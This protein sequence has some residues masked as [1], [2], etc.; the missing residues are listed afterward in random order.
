M[1]RLLLL[2]AGLLLS[3]CIQRPAIPN[4]AGSQLVGR[5]VSLKLPLHRAG[6]VM[7]LA[8]EKGKV[9]L[10]DLWATWCEPCV[11][12]LQVYQ[13]LQKEYGDRGLQIYAINVDDD[14]AAVDRFVDQ[15][16]LTLPVPL[17]PNSAVTAELLNVNQLPTSVLIDRKGKVRVVHEGFDETRLGGYQRE[18]EELLAEQP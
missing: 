16:R 17:D 12:Q 13:D 7:D 18:I 5:P 11:T 15:H 4:Y 9:V 2:S 8:N 10:L 14:S 6:G 3:S 1:R